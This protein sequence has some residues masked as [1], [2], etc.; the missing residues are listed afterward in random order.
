MTMLQEVY[1]PMSE[2]QKSQVVNWAK[3][4]ISQNYHNCTMK[5]STS[6]KKL[7]LSYVVK[8]HYATDFPNLDDDEWNKLTETLQ[9]GLWHTA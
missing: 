6:S 9:I 7:K 3:E 2:S 4:Q 1:D 8:G 5:D